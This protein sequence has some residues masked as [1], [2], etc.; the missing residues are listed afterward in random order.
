MRIAFL[1][2]FSFTIM[3]SFAQRKDTVKTGGKEEKLFTPNPKKAA[4]LSAILPG[5][6]QVYNKKYWKVPVIYTALVSLGYAIFW[7]NTRLTKV[8]K[9]VNTWPTSTSGAPDESITNAAITSVPGYVL[10]SY[11]ESRSVQDLHRRN[12]DYSTIIMGLFYAINI[13]DAA[14]D[15]HLYRFK[16]N[17]DALMS[18]DPTLIPTDRQNASLGMRLK[19]TF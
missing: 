17:E 19:I 11:S 12:K 1:I 6:G 7:N 18:L 10:D 13:V 14:V 2:L 4:M 16:I 5:L 8:N 3:L 9:V 15:A